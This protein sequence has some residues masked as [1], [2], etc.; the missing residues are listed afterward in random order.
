MSYLQIKKSITMSNFATVNSILAI[1]LIS[2][3][4]SAQTES[5]MATSSLVVASEVNKSESNYVSNQD[6]LP[7]AEPIFG[8]EKEEY[9]N[10][11][12]EYRVGALMDR[13]FDLN[14]MELQAIYA[15]S[16]MSEISMAFN[17][18][19]EQEVVVSVYDSYGQKVKSELYEIEH[20]LNNYRV[21]TEDLSDGFYS[22]VVTGDN[23]QFIQRFIIE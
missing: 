9:E 17:S 15:D 23:D 14:H 5:L 12:N 7:Y 19:V 1:L 4:I 22:M 2:T 18:T 21:R 3:S 6:F 13:V 10:H 8:I 20:G 16:K 11:F